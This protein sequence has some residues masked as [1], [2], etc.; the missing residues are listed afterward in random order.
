M[1]ELSTLELAKVDSCQTLL[2]E[3]EMVT[4]NPPFP[5]S[6]WQLLLLTKKKCHHDPITLQCMSDSLHSYLTTVKYRSTERVNSSISRF[7]Q[8]LLWKLPRPVGGPYFS[9]C[10]ARQEENCK[11]NFCKNFLS[12]LETYLIS[13][14]V[15][16]LGFEDCRLATHLQ[17]PRKVRGPFFDRLLP[18][19]R[20]RRRYSRN[21]AH[22]PRTFL[23]V[24]TGLDDCLIMLL[25]CFRKRMSVLLLT[26][27][28]SPQ[29]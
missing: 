9:C 15:T 21:K 2:S 6:V 28:C 29:S 5:T 14:C 13:A 12:N 16:T 17:T 27:Q 1:A 26:S 25:P 4:T 22:G 20:A 7:G 11:R 3:W 23:E 24:C 8:K 10:T 18:P 19:R